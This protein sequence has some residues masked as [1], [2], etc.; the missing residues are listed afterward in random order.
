MFRKKIFC[1]QIFQK[2]KNRTTKNVKLFR[3]KDG[4]K[5]CSHLFALYF[6]SRHTHKNIKIYSRTKTG[7]IL[8]VFVR[9]F[10]F[11][12]YKCSNF[13]SFLL[14]L[15]VCTFANSSHSRYLSVPG[16]SMLYCIC[17]SIWLSRVIFVES[18]TIYWNLLLIFI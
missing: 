4:Q 14:D 11:I 9:S 6:W 1:L 12:K 10:Y 8:S 15:V 17:P 3:N 2:S 7:K 13:R 18:T 5:I 16:L